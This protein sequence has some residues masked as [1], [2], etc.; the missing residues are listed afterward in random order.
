M[1]NK[2][3]YVIILVINIFFLVF[4]VFFFSY[5]SLINNKT[6]DWFWI[7]SIQKKLY[8]EG[9]LRNIFQ[10]STDCII[11]DENLFYKP[12]DGTCNFNNPE[13][14]TK[15]TFKDG[16]RINP[17]NLIYPKNNN[18]IILLG[19][20]V[21]MGWGVNDDEN[22]SAKLEKLIKSRIFNISVPNYGT[23]RQVKKLKEMTTLQNINNL[24][25]HYSID[26]YNENL[27]LSIKKKYEYIEFEKLFLNNLANQNKIFFLMRFYKKSFRILYHDIIKLI[28]PDKY[29]IDVDLKEHI[30]LAKKIIEDNININGKKI[31]I[32]FTVTPEMKISN[33]PEETD[34]FKI[35]IIE[36][37]KKHI[38][39]VDDHFNSV[40]HTFIANELF[41]YLNK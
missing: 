30:N 17:N 36:V 20:S 25:F 15:V 28:N 27:E 21:A 35:K 23:I 33:Y 7:N 8:F 38:F 39:K 24:I 2:F 4:I 32:L 37:D 31:I 22:Y 11:F 13:Y 1:I 18:S 40:G 16:I 5:V 12:K 3:F 9:G 41:F 10:A 29:L 26:D 34:K 6:Y 14:L 19:D